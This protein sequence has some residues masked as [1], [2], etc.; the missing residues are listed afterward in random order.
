MV[1]APL[2]PSPHYDALMTVQR[3]AAETDAPHN[4]LPTSDDATARTRPR[5]ALQVALWGTAVVASGALA[6][7][8]LAGLNPSLTPTGL[9][10]QGPKFTEQPQVAGAGVND[11]GKTWTAWDQESGAWASVLVRNTRPY[12]VTVS[13]ASAGNVVDVRVARGESPEQGGYIRPEDVTPV[14][15]LKVPSGGYVVVLLHVSDRCVEM[16]AGSATGG[17][18]SATVNVTS[19]G[20]THSLDVPFP[21]T[22]LAGTTTGHAADPSCA[23]G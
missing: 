2:L 17:S 5:R 10:W 12:P 1:A 9:S 3:P 16:S 22:Y 20:L 23:T 15:H 7:W 13:P 8:L 4:A 14:A 18:N 19:L 21:A 6:A 11:Q